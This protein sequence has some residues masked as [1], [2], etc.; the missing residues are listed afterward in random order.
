MS[1]ENVE[2]V[3][4][5]YDLFRRGDYLGALAYFDPAVETVEPNDMPGADAYVGHQGLADA[6]AHF[7]DA[8]DT[9]TVE[10]EQLTE[11]GNQV[12]AIARYYAIGKQSG[13]PVETTVAHVYAFENGRIVRWEMFNTRDEALKAVGLRK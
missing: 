4:R 9:Y 10:L 5:C 6:F 7:A 1:Q 13:I 8:W 3:K 2:V 12:V 11:A